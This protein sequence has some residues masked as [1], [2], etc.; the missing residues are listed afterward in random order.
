MID[1]LSNEKYS[2]LSFS[3]FSF[4]ASVLFLSLSFL[5]L[6]PHSPLSFSLIHHKALSFSSSFLIPIITI[7]NLRSFA[8]LIPHTLPLCIFSP[9]SP[10][11][12][13]TVYLCK[14]FRRLKEHHRFHLAIWRHH[15]IR[16][17]ELREEIRWVWL[18]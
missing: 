6:S 11:F 16:G 2:W 9:L 5:M 12:L 18:R 10:S 3:L 7:F 17:R 4:L 15:R 13:L 14:G 1:T 8:L